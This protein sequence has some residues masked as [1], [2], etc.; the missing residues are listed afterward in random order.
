MIRS[1]TLLSFAIIASL[2]ISCSNNESGDDS[3]ATDNPSA[4]N[5]PGKNPST[6]PID[7]PSSWTVIP[8][9]TLPSVYAILEK[10]AEWPVTDSLEPYDPQ[11][12]KSGRAALIKRNA[13]SWLADGV[14]PSALDEALRVDDENRI[15]LALETK[16]MRGSARSLR[17]GSGIVDSE[18]MNLAI[19]MRLTEPEFP[20]ELTMET[21]NAR[22]GEVLA[23]DLAA[24]L[25]DKPVSVNNTVIAAFG[26][27][28]GETDSDSQIMHVFAYADKEYTVVIVQHV[29]RAAR[30]L[31]SAEEIGRVLSA[32]QAIPNKKNN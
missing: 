23:A 9:T 32:Q 14:M 11:R 4:G 17:S 1:S 24:I 6:G 20:L 2:A 18:V 30:P 12:N 16:T 5:K 26:S 8:S 27:K 13:R 10:T 28:L 21:L 7:N 19:V 15:H 25:G 3:G 22:V 31:S 29:L